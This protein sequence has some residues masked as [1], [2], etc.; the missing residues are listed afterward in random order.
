MKCRVNCEGFSTSL[1]LILRDTVLQYFRV[2]SPDVVRLPAEAASHGFAMARSK[3]VEFAVSNHS[4]RTI[5][6]RHP[7]TLQIAAV[8]I[9]DSE[10]RRMNRQFRGKD[11]TTDVLTFVY[12]DMVEIYIS[13]PVA[14]KQAS[15]RKV[16]LA[17][18]CQRLIVHG[19]CHALGMDHH[20]RK[21]FME[22]R[23]REFEVLVQC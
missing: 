22:M 5:I 12:P 15:D 18:E 3:L 16:T 21:E 1:N 20:T 4:P 11:R 8:A 9:D 10:M 2:L 14:R 7:K 23:R 17:R 19:M 13:L 6:R